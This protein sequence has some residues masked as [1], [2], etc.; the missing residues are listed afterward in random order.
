MLSLFAMEKEYCLE[1]FS[2]IGKNSPA[3]VLLSGFLSDYCCRWATSSS[4]IFTD[5]GKNP[6]S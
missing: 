4:E 1:F 5:I 2:D 6:S 3:P